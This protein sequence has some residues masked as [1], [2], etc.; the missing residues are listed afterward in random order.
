M[1]GAAI[2]AAALVAATAVPGGYLAFGGG[3]D[4]VEIADPCRAR[5]W[6][7]P[8]GTARVAEQIVLSA[9]DGAAC[10]LGVSREELVLEL[11]QG[12]GRLPGADR[13]QVEQALRRG[14][15]RSVDD[16]ERAGALQGWQG[17]LL[18]LAVERIPV[19]QILD[20][21]ASTG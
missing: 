8:Q 15:R 1:K 13:S 17:A 21:V 4:P 12:D 16:A 10:E 9:L 3:S 20:Y 6:R 2:L 18:R 11:A 7:D 19:D 5:E 14:V